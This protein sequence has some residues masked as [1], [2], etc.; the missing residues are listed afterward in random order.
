MVGEKA[1]EPAAAK[2]IFK[3]APMPMC[4]INPGCEAA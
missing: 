2:R 4:P 3:P 1:A